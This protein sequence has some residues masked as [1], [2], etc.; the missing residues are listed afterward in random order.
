[1]MDGR[2]VDGNYTTPKGVFKRGLDLNKVS[3]DG[4]F[5]YVYCTTNLITNELYIG[6]CT[7]HSLFRSYIGSGT[8]LKPAIKKYGYKNFGNTILDYAENMEDLHKLE[9][10][11][12]NLFGADRNP[13]CYNLIIDSGRPMTGRTVSEK[14]KQKLREFNLGKKHTPET[15]ELIRKAHLG[16]KDTDEVKLKKSLSKKGKTFISEQQKID[17]SNTLK[18]KWKYD[19]EFRNR[20]EAINKKNCKNVYQYDSYGV[21]IAEYQSR[22]EAKNKVPKSDVYGFFNKNRQFSGGFIWSYEKYDNILKYQ[23]WSTEKN[24]Y[25]NIND[26]I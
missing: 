10:F 13:V 25:I 8:L 12:I 9:I 16:R 22:L 21:F 1:M 14:N 17:C 5:Y 2:I 24:K 3:A 20:M 26:G 6:K 18:H 19:I 11:Y 7:C 4:R 15:C 23:K